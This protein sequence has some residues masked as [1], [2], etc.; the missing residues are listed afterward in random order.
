MVIFQMLDIKMN[1][2]EDSQVEQVVLA[3]LYIGKQLHF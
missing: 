2:I 3:S 1:K